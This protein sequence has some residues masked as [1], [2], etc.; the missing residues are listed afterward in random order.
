MQH[1]DSPAAMQIA[2]QRGA[3]AFGQ[4]S[5][6]I[7]FGPKAQLTAHHQQ[8][9]RRTTSSACRPRSTASGSRT[10]PGAG[11]NTKH[12]D[13]GAL[14]QHARRREE[15]GR[16]TPRPRSPPASCI[17]SSARSTGQD[18]KAVECKG[19]TNLDDGQ[20]LGMNFYVKG[21]DDKIPGK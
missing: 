6:M 13:D 8:L 4:D 18:G 14:H 10:T 9:G 15:D 19:G 17:R 12:G 16:W 7:K 2:E 11:S 3:L 1:T 5:D 21:M 20:I